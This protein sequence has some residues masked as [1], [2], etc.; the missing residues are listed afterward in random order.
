MSKSFYYEPIN[1]GSVKSYFFTGYIDPDNN[2]ITLESLLN[3]QNSTCYS[4]IYFASILPGKNVRIDNWSLKDPYVFIDQKFYDIRSIGYYHQW[5]SKTENELISNSLSPPLTSAIFPENNIIQERDVSKWDPVYYI[6]KLTSDGTLVIYANNRN[7]WWGT[8]IAD[9][10]NTKNIEKGD[11]LEIVYNKSIVKNIKPL[12]STA[13]SFIKNEIP[14]YRKNKLYG[15][16]YILRDLEAGSNVALFQHNAW[17]NWRDKTIQY[18]YLNDLLPQGV[19]QISSLKEC[20]SSYKF[21][22]ICFGEEKQKTIK[23]L[24]NE[25]NNTKYKLKKILV[26][27][28]Y[29]SQC[30]CDMKIRIYYKN[31]QLQDVY[32]EIIFPYASMNLVKEEI[33]N[34]SAIDN[35]LNFSLQ[36]LFSGDSCSQEPITPNFYGVTGSFY[37]YTF[38]FCDKTHFIWVYFEKQ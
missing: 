7:Y 34:D 33:I 8:N 9:N 35:Q 27:K 16:L 38:D 28:E 4:E 14:E 13:L 12:P 20:T 31:N 5:K 29:F 2:K 3:S 37:I 36:I 18:E 10:G 22:E 1:L 25:L 23:E 11:Q 15:Y 30:L 17:T 24:E 21:K 6:K 32:R 19:I 26:Q